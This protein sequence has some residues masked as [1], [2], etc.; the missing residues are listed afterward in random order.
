MTLSTLALLAALP[1]F[2]AAIM[3][4]GFRLPARVAMPVALIITV[5]VALAVWKVAVVTLLATFMQSLFITFDI[6]YIIFAAILL[7]NFLTH[8]GGMQVIRSGFANISADR[9]VQVVIIVWFF[10]SFLEGASGFGT[11]AAIVAPLLL[12]LGFPALAAVMLGMMVQS[13]A[14]TFG[15]VGTPVLVGIRGGLQNDEMMQRLAALGLN[16]GDYLHKVTIHAALLHAV[17]GTLIPTFMVCMMTRIFGENKSWREGFAIFPF[18]LF[19]GL[20]FTV[21]Y[22]LTGIV[23]GPEFP[24][25]VGSL[26]G[27][28]ITIYAVKRGFLQPATVWNFPDGR[29]WPAAWSGKIKVQPEQK[30]EQVSM[31]AAWLPYILVV[32]LLVITRL[33]HL[34][35]KAFLS[36]ISVAW[37][38]ILGTSIS[39]VSTPLYLP[40]TIMMMACLVTPFLHRMPAASVK[41]A[42]TDSLK[43]IL[44]AGFVL[45]FAIPLVRIYIN[46]GINPYGYAGMPIVMA[47]WVSVN[48]GKIYPLFAPSVGALGAFIAG[49]N[50]VSNL[51]LSLFQFGVAERLLMPTTVMVA[52][53]AVGAAAGNMVAIH[54]IVAAS[55][56]VGFLGSEGLVLRKT[57]WPTLYY[58]LL[59][60]ALGWILIAWWGVADPLM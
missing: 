56:T 46:S 58:L 36:G 43:M 2:V 7:L 44:G 16:F 12:A 11:P 32:L 18:T 14:V 34:P 49:S 55:A 22:L 57:I 26:L 59:T 37:P 5:V 33:P 29:L 45:L 25:L 51:M 9:R 50:T 15:A 42:T 54:N 21:P 24:S 40:A 20:A 1:I 30:K 6:L 48:V 23:L 31:L 10:G 13:T 3:L 38:D 39:A 52:L 41:E 28:L 60:G 19:G 17:A 47:E 53:Q 35:L 8:S 27:V 4:V